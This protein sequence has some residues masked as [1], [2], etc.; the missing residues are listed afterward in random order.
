MTPE[1]LDEA[2]AK[3]AWRKCDA[4]GFGK[5]Y[6]SPAIIAARLAREGWTPPPPVDPEVLAYREWEVSQLT[7]HFDREK[8]L[9][10]KWDRG[11]TATAYLAGARMAREQEQERAKVLV[12]PAEAI[13]NRAVR[14]TGSNDL[15]WPHILKAAR[16]LEKGLNAYKA[17]KEAGK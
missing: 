15:R 13:V 4:L 10:G 16:R 7:D 11:V 12:E 17:G 14:G 9:A 6:E 8:V 3:E 2:R 5:D 1:E